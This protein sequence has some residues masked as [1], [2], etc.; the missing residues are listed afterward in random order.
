MATLVPGTEYKELQVLLLLPCTSAAAF[1][2]T[3]NRAAFLYAI[4]ALNFDKH[5][6][7]V[8]DIDAN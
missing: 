1:T 6:Q 8:I 5:L 3:W 7:L 2:T 4:V